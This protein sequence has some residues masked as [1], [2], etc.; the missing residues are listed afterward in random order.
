MKI[1]SVQNI[2][3]PITT[4]SNSSHSTS[5]KEGSVESEQITNEKVPTDKYSKSEKAQ[6][7]AKEYKSDVDTIARLKADADQKLQSFR[8][9]VEK[10]ITKQ[11]HTVEDVL[12][13]LSTNEEFMIEIDEATRLQAQAEISEDGYWGVTQTSERILDFAKALSGGDPAKID[14]LRDAF[15][16]GFENAKSTFGGKLPEISQKTYDAVLKGFEE[17]KNKE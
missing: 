5:K 12:K 14:L 1:P 8:N 11:G 9:L 6:V 10:L 3:P 7:P 4:K 15:L 13:A 16:E 2:H 17:W